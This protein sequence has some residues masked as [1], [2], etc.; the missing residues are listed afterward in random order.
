MYGPVEAGLDR[1]VAYGK[2]TD[3]IGQAA[4]LAERE[5]GGTLRL[6]TFV[7]D[8]DGIDVL[9]DEPIWHGGRVCGRVTSG[10]YAHGSG[11][12]VALGYV[13]KELAE[14]ETGWSIEIIDDKRDAVLRKD[15]LFDPD[16][17]RMRS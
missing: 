4:A 6:R 7:V 1:F 12:S 13:P 15:A 17:A 8:A 9:G 2:N 16:G 10:G 5:S 11:C 3:F 14:E